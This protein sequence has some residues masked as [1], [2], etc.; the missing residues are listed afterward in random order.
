PCLSSPH[1]LF[2]F[3]LLRGYAVGTFSASCNLLKIL[4]KIS[5]NFPPIKPN[6]T[7]TAT[8]I[9]AKII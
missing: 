4:W 1:S 7:I 2:L 6:T 9:N 3:L 8:E 5:F